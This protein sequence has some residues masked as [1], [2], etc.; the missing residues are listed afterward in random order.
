MRSRVFILLAC[1]LSGAILLLLSAMAVLIMPRRPSQQKEWHN[2]MIS[3]PMPS[4]AQE[5]RRDYGEPDHVFSVA[6]LVGR[7]ADVPVGRDTPTFPYVGG[8]ATYR[9]YVS[10][11]LW[12]RGWWHPK[13]QWPPAESFDPRWFE[14]PPASELELWLYE[15]P[16]ARPGPGKPQGISTCYVLGFREGILV[17]KCTIRPWEPQNLVQPP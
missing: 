15:D 11:T 1:V 8:Q 10:Y 17:Y 12:S 5:V 13:R 16:W 6:E 9:G 7:V 4:T 14:S 2:Q 3:A